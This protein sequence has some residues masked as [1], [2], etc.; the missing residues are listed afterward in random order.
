[1]SMNEVTLQADAEYVAFLDMYAAEDVAETKNDDWRYADDGSWEDPE[2]TAAWSA[3][4][5]TS[6]EAR[7]EME[8]DDA[9]FGSFGELLG[10]WS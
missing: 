5:E 8:A 4:F 6:H 7:D 1:M 2:G 3:R 10:S 9:R